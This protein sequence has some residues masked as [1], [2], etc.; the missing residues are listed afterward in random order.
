M[1]LITYRSAEG[2]ECP[3]RLEGGRVTDLST[4]APDLIALASGGERALI[5]ARECA[6]PSATPLDQVHILAPITRPGK[7]VCVAGN[8]VEHVRE[9]GATIVAKSKQS[10]QLF[11]KPST[12]IVGVDQPVRLPRASLSHEVDWECELAVVIGS[13]AT[14][15]PASDALNHVLGYTVF[16]DISARSIEHS[17]DYLRS[18]RGGFFDWLHGKWFDTFGP[19]GPCI[20]TRDEIPDPSRLTL[21]LRLNGEV[22]QHASVNDMIFSVS[23]LIEFVSALVTLEP[24]DVLSTGTASGTGIATGRLL[25]A[26]DVMEAEIDGIGILRSPVVAQ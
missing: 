5:A 22:R 14:S 19:M 24:G 3:G 20:V 12:T 9:G 1:R 2:K 16:N 15:V 21:E 17:P 6:T 7:L 4:V 13:T 25:R 8:Y 18:E 10:P 26:G 11:M 23:E